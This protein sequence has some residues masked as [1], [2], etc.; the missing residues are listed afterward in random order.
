MNLKHTALLI[1]LLIAPVIAVFHQPINPRWLGVIL[2]LINVYTLFAYYSDKRRAEK[3]SWRVA[4]ARLH[5]LELIGGWPAAFIAQK[6]FRHK[7]SKLGYQ[8]RYWSI[9]L[10]WQLAALDFI[11]DGFLAGLVD[12]AIK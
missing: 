12:S 8:L 9:I 3:G 4:E 2:L 6:T 5:L 11:F 7:C 1:A 10:I